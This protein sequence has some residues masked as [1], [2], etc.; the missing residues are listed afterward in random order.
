MP[1]R[2]TPPRSI[3]RN[4]NFREAAGRSCGHGRGNRRK[5]ALDEPPSALAKDANRDFSTRQILLVPKIPVG[6]DKHIESGGFRGVQQLTVS[7]GIPAMRADFLDRVTLQGA[8]D[9]SR[10]TVVE[11]DAH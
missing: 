3:D 1:A 8:R 5:P 2:P 9:A 6:G 4:L 10:R 11:E 7:E